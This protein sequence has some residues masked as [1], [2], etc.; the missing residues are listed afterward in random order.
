[1]VDPNRIKAGNAHVANCPT[2][3]CVLELGSSRTC[4]GCLRLPRQ[5][6]RVIHRR[7]S[8]R[9]RRACSEETGKGAGT[10]RVNNAHLM[11]CEWRA[12]NQRHTTLHEN[13]ITTAMPPRCSSTAL[14]KAELNGASFFTSLYEHEYSYQGP[15]A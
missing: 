9:Q 4:R 6:R 1:M 13:D 14:K 12:M 5:G 7:Y 3:P 15:R 2:P 8:K 11:R 10:L